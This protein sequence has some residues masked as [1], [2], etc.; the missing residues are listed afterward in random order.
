MTKKDGEIFK[1]L[2]ELD[3]RHGEG[4]IHRRNGDIINATWR[5]DRKHGQ[6]VVHTSDGKKH[7][8]LFYSDV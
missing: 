1:G 6:A 4:E 5:N 2:F 7:H 3:L 8:L